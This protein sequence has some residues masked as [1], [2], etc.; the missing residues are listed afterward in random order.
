MTKF[1][2]E[3][4]KSISPIAPMVPKKLTVRGLVLISLFIALQIILTRF[5]SIQTPIVRID[6]NFLA[7]SMCS[8]IF[9]PIWGGI[10]AAAA[11][12]IGVQLFPSSG[13]YFPGFTITMFLMGMTYGVFL[14]E[15]KKSYANIACAVIIVTMFLSLFLDTIWITMLTGK[16]FIVL[17]PT[18]L[19]KAA[20]MLPVQILLIDR[21]WK[22]IGSEVGRLNFSN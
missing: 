9:G 20:I 14:H 4:L 22:T 11:D 8:I 16:G 10:A 21:V 19:T 6:L 7:V 12:F 3:Q 17:L 15:R 18:R 13:A 2:A 1:I 5:C